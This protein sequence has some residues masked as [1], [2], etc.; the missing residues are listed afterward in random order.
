MNLILK[1][2]KYFFYLV[3]ILFISYFVYF[4]NSQ[5][6]SKKR[7]RKEIKNIIKQGSIV[8]N[9]YNDY[10][11]VFLP[12]T[13]FINLNFKEIKLDFLNLNQC[14]F[15][16]C[17]TFFLEQHADKLIIADRNTEIRTIKFSDVLNNKFIFE[18]FNTNLEIDYILD[19]KIYE[20]R[21]YV[22]GKK[23]INNKTYIE[24]LR[25]EIINNQ[26]NFE[27]IIQLN[28]DKCFLR[29][30]V[31]SG[32]I[33]FFEN[34]ENKI[35]L[36]INGSGSVDNGTLDTLKSDNICGKILLIEPI[37]KSYDIFSYGHRNITGLYSDE[38]IILATE[39]GPHAGDEINRIEKNKKYGWPVSSYG[40]KYSRNKDD[41]EPNY[42]KSHK[43]HGFIEPIFSFIPAIGISE[44][45][46]LPNS[47]SKIWQNNFLVGSLNGK[48]L[49]RVKFDDEFNKIIY[50]EPIYIGDRIRDLIYHKESESI[51]MALELKGSIGIIEKKK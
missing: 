48:Y 5:D 3:L 32:K 38:N 29:D 14:Y 4:I 42:K 46:M 39:H 6:P 31:H 1:L 41:L 36:T 12:E 25:G 28:S 23:N 10:R 17:H 16:K 26:I 11:E 45:I 22:S 7:L 24:V 37:S 33:E 49:Y 30:S 27:S 47:F 40:E 51:F 44:I 9:L 19:V 2:I 8:N 35:L 13:Q 20:N 15:G 43:L 21:L 18:I 50:Y 34:K